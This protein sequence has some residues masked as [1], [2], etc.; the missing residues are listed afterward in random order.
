[1]K[2]LAVAAYLSLAVWMFADTSEL[3]G[4]WIGTSDSGVEL[5]LSLNALVGSVVTGT[6]SWNGGKE[7]AISNG[8]VDGGNLY[9]QMPS[10]YGGST[11]DVEGQLVGDKLRL[12]LTSS[13]GEGRMLLKRQPDPAQ[14]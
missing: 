4:K 10:L 12:K 3:S 13:R 5:Q 1:M 14:K 9:F 6:A 11:L 2:I 7:N 8:K